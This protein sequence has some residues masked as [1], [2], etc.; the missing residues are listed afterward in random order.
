[1]P[2]PSQVIVTLEEVESFSCPPGEFRDIM[3]GQLK[4]SFGRKLQPEIWGDL[5]ADLWASVQRLTLFKKLRLRVKLKS[6]TE[7]KEE[8]HF[9][10]KVFFTKRPAG[11]C[12]RWEMDD[13][14]EEAPLDVIFCM[15]VTVKVALID[16]LQKSSALLV[17]KMK[18]EFQVWEGKPLPKT[19]TSFVNGMM[20]KDLCK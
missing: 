2:F 5:E 15:E 18:P 4:I 13:E 11:L 9:N 17:G 14:D 7:N 6:M 20:T 12:G 19:L 10:F 16:S 1:M 3:T 8:G